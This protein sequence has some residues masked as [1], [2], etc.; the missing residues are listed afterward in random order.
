MFEKIEGTEEVYARRIKMSWVKNLLD[1]KIKDAN[2]RSE[3]VALTLRI[4]C[5]KEGNDFTEDDLFLDEVMIIQNYIMSKIHL[6]K[7]AKPD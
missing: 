6:K 7:K 1:G 3:M 2:M 5:D 4:I